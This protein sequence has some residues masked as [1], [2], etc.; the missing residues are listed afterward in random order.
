M[1]TVWVFIRGKF[2]SAWKVHLPYCAGALKPDCAIVAADSAM[3]RDATPPESSVQRAETDRALLDVA[4]NDLDRLYRRNADLQARVHAQAERE[5][6]HVRTENGLR[7]VR[8]AAERALRKGLKETTDDRCKLA[9]RRT[10]LVL[11]S[12]SRR[13]NGGDD[14]DVRA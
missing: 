2:R 1:L 11:Y 4:H 6:E 10:L 12:P 5:A 13:P 14:D 8:V 7:A 9:M 3:K